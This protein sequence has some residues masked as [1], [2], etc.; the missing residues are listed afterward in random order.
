MKVAFGSVIYEEAF[1][2]ASDFIHSLNCQTHDSFDILLLNDNVSTNNLAYITNELRNDP[3]IWQCEEGLQPYQLRVEL[4]KEAKR[5]NYDL[6]ILGDFDDTFSEDRISSI[7]AAYDQN[8]AFFYN[9]LYYINSSRKFFSH[10]PEQTLCINAIIESNYI[11]LS[12]SAI[13]LNSI[14]EAEISKWKHCQNAVFDWYMYSVLLALGLKG[15]RVDEGKTFYRIHEHNIAGE[16][17]AS[18]ENV[19]K[20]IDIKIKHYAS[21]KHRGKCFNEYLQFYQWLKSGV[22]FSNIKIEQ[23]MD[24]GTE[25]WWGNIQMINFKKEIGEDSLHDND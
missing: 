17:N 13:N 25:Y 11:G 2:Y 18:Y 1:T 22:Q 8:Y 9:N 10:L 6:L 24:T 7:V 15:K 12:N 21:L 19:M 5:R 4:I 14:E 20:E 3:V 16:N 23:Y